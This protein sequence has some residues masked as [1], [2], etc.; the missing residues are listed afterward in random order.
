MSLANFHV[1]FITAAVL[2]CLGYA[3]W[4]FQQYQI[5]A[6]TGYLFFSI[7][8]ALVA[9]GLGVYEWRFVKKQKSQ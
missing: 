7:L 1:L 8:T 9:V 3:Y 6:G 5:G 2:L 4:N